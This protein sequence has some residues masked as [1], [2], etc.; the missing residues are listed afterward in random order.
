MQHGIIYSG[1]RRV[2]ARR[3]AGVALPTRTFVYGPYEAD[4]LRGHGGYT[5]EE[6]VVTGAP[7]LAFVAVAD[8]PLTGPHARDPEPA[9]RRAR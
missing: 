2:R 1:P 9:R 3:S 8:A 4:V 6:V 7:R 5:D